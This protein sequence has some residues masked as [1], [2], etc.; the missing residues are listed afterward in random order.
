MK[1]RRCP[2]C[3][4]ALTF[5][6]YYWHSPTGHDIRC[7]SCYALVGYKNVHS[8]CIFIVFFIAVALYLKFVFSPS[9]LPNLENFKVI[10]L[11]IIGGL[12]PFIFH[13]LAP[14]EIKQR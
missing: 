4:N 3:G 7:R 6:D 2:K 12:I 1:M 13:L 14:L 10:G 8:L 11:V 5:A 9:F